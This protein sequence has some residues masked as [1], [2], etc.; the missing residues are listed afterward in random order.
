MPVKNLEL[1]SIEGKRFVKRD[2]PIRHLNIDIST[3]IIPQAQTDEDEADVKFTHSVTYRGVGH[4]IIEGR[5][6]FKGDA[7]GLMSTWQTNRNMPE[8]VA[9]ELHQAIMGVCIPESV[10]LAR[11]LNLMIPLPPINFDPKKARKGKV[12]S[13]G[14]MEVA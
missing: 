11:D 3:Q 1:N 6:T 13:V 2:E 14:G 10:I 12:D 8:D 9:R 7:A 4:I 5:L